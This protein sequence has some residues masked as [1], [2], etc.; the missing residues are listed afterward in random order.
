MGTIHASVRDRIAVLAIDNPAK[1]NAWDRRMQ[2]E[3]ARQ[4]R[5]CDGSADVDAIVITG[6]GDRAFCAGQDLK[7]TLDFTPEDI[8][9]WLEGLMDLYEAPLGARKPVVAAIRGIAVGSGYQFTLMCD[10][11]V[12]HD[13]ARIGQP[14]VKNGIPSVTGY[15]LTERALG[16]TRAVDLMLTG[17]LLS[18]EESHRIGLVQELVDAD[19]VLDRA[20]ALAAE[21]AAMPRSAFQKTKKNIKD[22]IWPGLEDAFARARAIDEAAWQDEEPTQ[23]VERF[24]AGS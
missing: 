10:L 11:R 9:P 8:G 3:L 13:D 14:E 23:S 24:F 15:F 6:S 4:I 1:L 20:V 18:G 21:L 12:T 2:A 19:Q 22:S 17:R 7:E 16:Y 5:R